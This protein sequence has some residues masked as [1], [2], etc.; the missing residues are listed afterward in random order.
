MTAALAVGFLL[1]LLVFLIHLIVSPENPFR[2]I[3]STT[4]AVLFSSIPFVCA[5]SA[6]LALRISR[7][8]ED[9]ANRHELGLEP[10]R[11]QDGEQ[12]P[13]A[14]SSAEEARRLADIA[15]RE[16]KH[17]LTSIVGYSLT[18]R[19]YWDK[20]S[21]EERKEFVDFIHLSSVRLEGMVNDLARILELT[22]GLKKREG[23]LVDLRE[24]AEEVGQILSEVHRAR[25]I[26]L[27]LRFPRQEVRVRADPVS[28]FDLLYNLFDLCMRASAE[29]SVVSAW[30]NQLNDRVVLRLRC[31]RAQFYPTRISQIVEH[32][33]EEE[34]DDLTTLA[35]QYRLSH[36][37][38]QEMGGH[39]TVSELGDHGI[40]L[41][42]QLPTS[43]THR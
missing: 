2:F 23:E 5:A 12:G 19:H 18:L 15:A 43:T 10:K 33:P 34:D 21:E 29:R 13:P 42:A 11:P 26:T 37:M 40:S 7:G 27:N 4:S 36:L 16:I 25:K 35:M 30:F 3:S 8:S 14:P 22:R 20:L 17:P 41:Q 24:T 9:T 31:P 38:I 32:W 28:L 1:D 39:L 6:K